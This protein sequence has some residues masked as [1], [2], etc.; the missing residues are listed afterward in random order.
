[1]GG[2]DLEHMEYT[3]F[4]KVN[5]TI[6]KCSKKVKTTPFTATENYVQSMEKLRDRYDSRT[7]IRTIIPF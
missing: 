6:L 5:T 3:G 4:R 1:V 7:G 2:K